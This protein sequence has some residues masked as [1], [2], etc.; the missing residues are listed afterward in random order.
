LGQYYLKSHS[1]ANEVLCHLKSQ[2]SQFF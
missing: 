2:Y 1:L